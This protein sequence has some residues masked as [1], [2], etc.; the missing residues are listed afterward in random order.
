M[1]KVV[2]QP[3]CLPNATEPLPG[4]EQPCFVCENGG[5]GTGTIVVSDSPTV[6]L[7]GD[8]S[9]GAPLVATVK[10]F[11][12]YFDIVF[13]AMFDWQ[14]G[15]LLMC[16]VAPR[17]YTLAANLAGSVGNVEATPAITS[18]IDFLRNGVIFA[19]ATITA[20]AVV[21]TGTEADFA[22]NDVLSLKSSTQADF[23]CVSL[24]L[25]ALRTLEIVA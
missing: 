17:P 7:A 14:A 18:S 2:C 1:L 20:N 11:D 19:T 16:Y 10:P 23:T 4:V 12:T 5:G 3:P 15:Q 6:D 9:A 21:F 8:G 25:L 22:I 13:N 24:T